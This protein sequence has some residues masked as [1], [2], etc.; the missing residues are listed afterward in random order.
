MEGKVCLNGRYS[1]KIGT[2]LVKKC[3]FARSMVSGMKLFHIILQLY[4]EGRISILALTLNLI[5]ISCKHIY[6]LSC[7]QW[8]S[9]SV[10]L[11]KQQQ[12]KM[13]IHWINVTYLSVLK[14]DQI[15]LYGTFILTVMPSI[16]IAVFVKL[17]VVPK[18]RDK[19]SKY[20]VPNNPLHH[21]ENKSI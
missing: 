19:L 21:T 6:L 10:Y 1:L 12:Q 8:I 2:C 18:Q 3:N 17:V 14:F 7:E 16:L 5:T 11:W 20:E 13:K 15:P 9:H 4:C